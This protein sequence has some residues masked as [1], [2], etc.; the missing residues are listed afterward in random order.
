MEGSN[1]RSFRWIVE[2]RYGRKAKPSKALKVNNAN[3]KPDKKLQDPID[4]MPPAA[5]LGGEG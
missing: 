4:D 2:E 3:Y 1:T 5:S